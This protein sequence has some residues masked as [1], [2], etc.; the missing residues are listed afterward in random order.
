MARILVVDDDPMIL[1]LLVEI[2]N[3][4]GYDV[5]TTTSGDEAIRISEAWLPNVAI[6]DVVMPGKGGLETIMELRQL[7]PKTRI[8]VLTGRVPTEATVLDELAA[9]FGAGSVLRKPIPNEV[10]LQAVETALASV[11]RSDME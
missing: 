7:V 4:P 9:S 5:R 1:Q 11:E 8:L 10:L 2:L 3:K 6:V